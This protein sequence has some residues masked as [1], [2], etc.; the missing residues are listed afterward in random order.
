MHTD[1]VGGSTGDATSST[2]S[3]NGA[4]AVIRAL[5]LHQPCIGGRAARL[6]GNS[7]RT[8]GNV[9][10]VSGKQL[11]AIR[12][13]GTRQV[14][15]LSG[16]ASGARHIIDGSHQTIQ[17]GAHVA[18]GSLN[19]RA[20]QVEGN[21]ASVTGSV[22]GA[23]ASTQRATGTKSHEGVSFCT[24]GD[25]ARQVLLAVDA[26]SDIF[27]G[28]ASAEINSSSR[29][30]GTQGQGLG[31]HLVESGGACSSSRIKSRVRKHG[32]CS[33]H[34]VGAVRQALHAEVA[35]V[36]RLGGL[37]TES[38]GLV[39][40]GAHLELG[41]GEI[42][43]QQVQA[44]ELGGVGH[45][46]KFGQQLADF[47]LQSIA[48][49]G[50]VGVVGGLHSQGANALQDIARSLQRAFSGLRDRDAVIRVTTGLVQAIDLRG[51]TL[52]DRQASSVIL[53]AI[54]AQTGGQALHGSAQADAG[55]SQFA[56]A[57]EGRNVRIDDHDDSS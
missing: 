1:G 45:A 54:D 16:H 25:A 7:C 27:G 13:R 33:N 36:G 6:N 8:N 14:N 24:G 42:A 49:G 51:H 2:S 17:I 35:H 52:G 28:Q 18:G 9:A 4:V 41:F 32:L 30:L 37:Q 15:F 23:S 48:V 47:S 20:I 53:G 50:A 43:V 56:L 46:I 19:S 26:V 12:A 31:L 38:D 29:T 11:D 10:T 5:Q 34:G 55:A 21:R 57:I 22:T 39:G 44:V 3:H 40:V